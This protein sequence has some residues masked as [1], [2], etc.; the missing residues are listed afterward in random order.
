MLIQM[1]TSLTLFSILSP[2]GDPV[3]SLLFTEAGPVHP[4]PQHLSVRQGAGRAAMSSGG[5]PGNCY[6]LGAHRRAVTL[7][8]DLAK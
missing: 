3:S 4:P 7:L 1:T 6:R 8:W 5:G 2:P